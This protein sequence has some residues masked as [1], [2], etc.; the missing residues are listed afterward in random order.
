ML[1]LL[2][3]GT[4]TLLFLAIV[5][6]GT[7]MRYEVDDA[8]FFI[9]PAL[10]GWFALTSGR[11]R[12]VIA[13]L[14]A[15]GHSLRLFGRTAISFSG[16]YDGLR[17]D[18]SADV[19]GA[20][21]AHQPAPDGCGDDPRPSGDRTSLSHGSDRERQRS[22]YALGQAKFGLSST[23][24]EFDII[25]PGNG[26]WSFAPT[27]SRA[28]HSGNAPLSITV[29]LDDGRV[30]EVAIG[31]GRTGIPLSLHRGLN[32]IQLNA[33]T[34]DRKQLGRDVVSVDG[35]RLVRT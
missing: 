23:P 9:L 10:I 5:L 1:A 34:R 31:A 21:P 18:A 25:S 16:Y 29:R 2:A 22:T 19:L 7:T 6:P 30:R 14:G 24:V 35:L 20:R 32:R 4:L 11:G 8:T 26:D 12:R 3:V 28:P 13:V 15:P 33:T 27:F 17:T